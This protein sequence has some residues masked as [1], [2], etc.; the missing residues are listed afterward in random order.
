MEHKRIIKKISA[1]LCFILF[2]IFMGE[3]L[4]AQQDIP[5]QEHISKELK[6]IRESQAEL[7]VLLHQ[8]LDNQEELKKELQ[9]IKIRSSVH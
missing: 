1:V 3:L 2:I 8:I 6:E 7:N 5:L 9:I 4:L